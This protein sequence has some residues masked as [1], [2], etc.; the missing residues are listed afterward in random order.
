MKEDRRTG[1]T[2]TTEEISMLICETEIPKRL[3]RY[4]SI[5][6]CGRS[7]PSDSSLFRP[8]LSRGGKINDTQFHSYSWSKIFD[9]HGY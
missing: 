5:N 6:S 3:N 9:R 2:T 4:L 7:K 1:L 8:R